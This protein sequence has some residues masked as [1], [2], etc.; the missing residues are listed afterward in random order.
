MSNAGQIESGGILLAGRGRVLAVAVRD[1]QILHVGQGR[2]VFRAG[3]AAGQQ[4]LAPGWGVYW[5]MR[6]KRTW[7]G[8]KAEATQSM[9]DLA[10]SSAPGR[11]RWRMT[12][13][14]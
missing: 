12:T 2:A 8:R 9:T 7:P 10:L 13:P 4:A 11:S 5:D 3:D 1:P 14:F 6:E